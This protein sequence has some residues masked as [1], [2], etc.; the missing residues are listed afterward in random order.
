[1]RKKEI[2]ATLF[3]GFPPVGFFSQVKNTICNDLRILAYH[4]VLD[5]ANIENYPYDHELISASREQFDYQIKYISKYF[6]PISE[7]QLVDHLENS[8]S[9]PRRPIM[10]TFDDGFNDNYHNAFPILRK[11]KVPATIFI[12][13]GNIDSGKTLWFD[14]LASLIYASNTNKIDV[15]LLKKEYTRGDRETNE[16]IM[17]DLIIMLRE[18]DNHTRLDILNQLEQ[19]Y[20]D[21][22]NEID[23]NLSAVLTWDQ[24]REMSNNGI[25]IGSH[26]VT[27]PILSRINSDELDYE[28]AES[29]SVIEKQLNKDVL[30]ISYP[31]GMTESFTD[32][33]VTKVR[34]IGYKIAYTYLHNNNRI[35]ISDRYRL[36]RLHVE[37]HVS[38]SYFKQMLNYPL[39][40]NN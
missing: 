37:T 6:N 36:K 32:E 33:V 2:L 16:Q 11:Y 29:K 19:Q 34:D 17:I 30:S 3:E 5:I 8:T 12:T 14:W 20:S 22:V 27:H 21:T 38:N 28:L 1:M 40:F 13:S 10:V 23:K 18:V 15:P 35:P 7:E 26:T 25:S 31:T 9:L 4:R 39:L 24:V